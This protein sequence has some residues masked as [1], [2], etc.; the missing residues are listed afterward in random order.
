MVIFFCM[1]INAAKASRNSLQKKMFNK[2][3]VDPKGTVR[4]KS[5]PEEGDQTR[6]RL[7]TRLTLINGSLYLWRSMGTKRKDDA[8]PNDEGQKNVDIE[9]N[10]YQDIENNDLQV[11]ESTEKFNNGKCI[12]EDI[13]EKNIYEDVL[14][15]ILLSSPQ[16]SPTLKEDLIIAKKNLKTKEDASGEKKEKA[17]KASDHRTQGKLQFSFQK[18][19]KHKKPT[20]SK[21]SG[22]K[23][24]DATSVDAATPK[25]K[26]KKNKKKGLDVST[27][28]DEVVVLQNYGAEL[29]PESKPSSS[30]PVSVVVEC[31]PNAS[32]ETSKEI[33]DSNASKISS[34]G[35]QEKP[36]LTSD[37]KSLISQ[38][39]KHSSAELSPTT[40][41]PAAGAKANYQK[42]IEMR[43]SKDV[44][45]SEPNDTD[46]KK[47]DKNVS[48]KE[49]ELKKKADKK[50]KKGAGKDDVQRNGSADHM[51]SARN[52]LLK[53]LDTIDDHDGHVATKGLEKKQQSTDD[54]G[55][56]LTHPPDAQSRMKQ[57]GSLARYVDGSVMLAYAPKKFDGSCQ[58]NP[59]RLKPQFCDMS[60]DD[61]DNCYDYVRDL[62]IKTFVK[63]Q[64]T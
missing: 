14:D 12:D 42:A 57:D 15:E 35:T 53:K 27:S 3:F 18:K 51:M 58:D 36:T 2:C 30:Q 45:T 13:S 5:D 48:E 49:N 41:V 55:Y 1:L 40:P 20:D 29:G 63:I 6:S 62:P 8:P 19:F 23:T 43:H 17:G 31:H 34:S 26:A 16:L 4:D 60:S 9:N 59:A 37:V 38:M 39:E 64:Q 33:F 11:S 32:Y 10:T 50:G 25:K 61:E 52:V 56:V 24:K 47:P 46:K 28:Q 22:K 7:K 21:D 54:D 44:E